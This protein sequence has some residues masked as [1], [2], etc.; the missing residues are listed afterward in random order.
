M[1]GMFERMCEC[2]KMLVWNPRGSQWLFG[3]NIVYERMSGRWILS[4]DTTNSSY[5][6][7]RPVASQGV[8]PHLPG[9]KAGDEFS[10]S[11]VQSIILGT[12]PNSLFPFGRQSGPWSPSR[13]W[14]VRS[15]CHD[16]YSTSLQRGAQ[17]DQHRADSHVWPQRGEVRCVGGGQGK[18]GREN[19][20][21]VCR[22][23]GKG[24]GA[25]SAPVCWGLKWPEVQMSQRE[26][27][28][29]LD[30]LAFW[31]GP[32]TPCSSEE[33]AGG[34]GRGSVARVWLR[35]LHSFD[36]DKA[37]LSACAMGLTR[38]VLSMA[39]EGKELEL[40]A[41]GDPGGFVPTK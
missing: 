40:K 34:L 5:P 29:V 18:E 15:S 41:F 32:H 6:S 8:V 39:K 31:K 35:C 19:H 11:A 10:K 36:G 23:C 25:D 21:G 4:K 3:N 28:D 38:P 27:L 37:E 22:G 20:F 17:L 9:S 30:M 1:G 7:S 24:A 33:C 16:L 2:V 13:S 26:Q 14:R 12:V